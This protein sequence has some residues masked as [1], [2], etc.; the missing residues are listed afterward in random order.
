MMLGSDSGAT[1]AVLGKIQSLFLRLC[2]GRNITFVSELGS[3]G[4]YLFESKLKS[5]GDCRFWQ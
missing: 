5:F 1:S 4:F 2:S 3:F